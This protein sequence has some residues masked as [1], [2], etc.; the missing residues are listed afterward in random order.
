M[1]RLF[2]IQENGRSDDP[3]HGDD[4]VLVA[5]PVRY[6][7][8]STIILFISAVTVLCLGIMTGLSIYRA[9]GR[10]RVHR[11]HGFC[12][13]PYDSQAIDNDDM[14]FMNQRFRENGIK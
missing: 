10:P 8:L 7:R 1:Q 6:L 9:Y 5:K 12:G 11:F 13:V 14:I 2:F 4:I 3:E